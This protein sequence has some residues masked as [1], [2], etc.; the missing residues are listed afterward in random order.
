MIKD[1]ESNENNFLKA[2][3]NNTISD[4]RDTYAAQRVDK[5]HL[6]KFSMKV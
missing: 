4:L 2:Q 1:S 5:T 6:D 3:K